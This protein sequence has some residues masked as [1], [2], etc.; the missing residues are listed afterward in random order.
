[1]FTP[2]RKNT[3]ATRTTRKTT[4]KNKVKNVKTNAHHLRDWLC[5]VHSPEPVYKYDAK[6]GRR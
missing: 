6:I 3:N 5:Y 2:R 4:G 1:M